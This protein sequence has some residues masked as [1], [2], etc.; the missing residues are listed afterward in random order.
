MQRL[1][2]LALLG[3]G[4]TGAHA[5]STVALYEFN[6]NFDPVS[7]VG[8]GASALVSVDPLSLGAFVSDTVNGVNRTVYRFDGAAFPSTDQGGLQ[9][10][11]ADLMNPDSYSIEAYFSFD[12]V[13]GWRRI[14]DTRDRTED[15]GFYVLNGGLQLYPSNVGVGAFAADVYNHVILTFDGA[16]AVAYLDGVAQ[17]TQATSY[18]SLPASNVISLFLDNTI[19]VAPN[20]YSAGKIAWARFYDGALNADEALA[21]YRAAVDFEV[22]PPIPEPSTY[23]LMLTGGA[24]MLLALRRRRQ[25]R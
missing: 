22:P 8:S 11:N 9:F 17:S 24:A 4:L 25:A 20:E 14:V 6:G 18:Y 13:S 7:G 2:A 16:T 15:T 12:E 21:A 10:V 23:A 1:A 19:S 3:A 5:A